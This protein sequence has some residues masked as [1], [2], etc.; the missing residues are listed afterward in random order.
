MK[1]L[2]LSVAL[3]G[4]VFS[5]FAGAELFPLPSTLSTGRATIEI[6]PDGEIVGHVDCP[7]VGS[8]DLDGDGTPEVEVAG[9]TLRIRIDDCR[10]RSYDPRTGVWTVDCGP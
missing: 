3:A 1:R 2:L 8:I 10:E 5:A 9:K 6:R 4:L 7:P